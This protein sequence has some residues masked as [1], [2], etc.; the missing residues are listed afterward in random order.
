MSSEVA[1][2]SSNGSQGKQKTSLTQ[3]DMNITDFS[4]RFSG[5]VNQH[6]ALGVVALPDQLNDDKTLPSYSY[7]SL[8]SFEESRRETNAKSD[9]KQTRNVDGSQSSESMNEYPYSPPSKSDSSESND[10]RSGAPIYSP[11]EN[12]GMNTAQA[13]AG[14]LTDSFSQKNQD[15]NP[16]SYGYPHGQDVNAGNLATANAFAQVSSG[17]ASKYRYLFHLLINMT[18]VI[19]HIIKITVIFAM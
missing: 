11:F 16:Y 4:T 3:K 18:K 14:A 15:F 9:G 5:D 1:G 12:I 10:L 17:S 2:D 19:I 6:P 8:T 13:Y 7:N